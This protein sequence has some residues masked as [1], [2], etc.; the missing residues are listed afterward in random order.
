MTSHLL[1]PLT[2]LSTLLTAFIAFLFWYRVHMI[3]R[4]LDI[5]KSRKNSISIISGFLLAGWFVLVLLFALADIY[6]VSEDFLSPLVPIGFALP[7]IIGW[8]LMKTSASFQMV[9][10]KLTQEWLI[11]LQF[12]RTGGIIF[13]LLY[14]Q[15][16]LPALFA[17][18][19]GIGDLIVGLSAPIVAYFCWK[20]TSFSRN[21]VIAWNVI[22]I[23]DLILAITF[24][25]LLVL[26][27]Q[28]TPITSTPST[29]LMTIFPLVLVPVFAVPFG[30]LLHIFSLRLLFKKK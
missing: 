22:G 2:I 17:F 10:D 26:P 3:A 30:I 5:S 27:E 21:L 18:S 9:L 12:Y 24:G 16:L 23:I 13:I 15:G 19:A 1:S 11:A 8:H 4:S 7:F 28:F 25:I 20:K 6:H 14:F 29:E